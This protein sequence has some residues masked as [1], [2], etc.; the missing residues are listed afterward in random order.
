MS[1]QPTTRD[2]YKAKAITDEE[3]RAAVDAY[4]ADP[5]TSLFAITERYSLDLAGAVRSH[6]WAQ[7][8]VSNADATEYL[9]RTAVCTAIL[10]ARPEKR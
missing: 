2:L 5:A 7:Q 1:D 4:M 3:V 6:A 8:T 10:L 9:K